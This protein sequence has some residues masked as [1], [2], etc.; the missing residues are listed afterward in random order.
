MI[1]LVLSVQE[2]FKAGLPLFF[3][4]TEKKELVILLKFDT[5]VIGFMLVPTIT[6]G[7]SRR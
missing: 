3:I 2:I 1:D 7:S 4:L 6:A 5:R